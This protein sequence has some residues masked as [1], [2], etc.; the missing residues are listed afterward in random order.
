[1]T[2]T[3][4]H[5]YVWKSATSVEVAATLLENGCHAINCYGINLD[6]NSSMQLANLIV[7]GTQKSKRR[8]REERNRIELYG[9]AL[10]N[11]NIHC[12][13]P[14]LITLKYNS[15]LTYLDLK[16]NRIGDKGAGLIASFM[17]R[18]NSLEEI[19][20]NSNQIGDQGAKSIAKAL[21]HNTALLKIELSRNYIGNK[22][23]KC[24]LSL[25]KTNNTLTG[26][27]LHH[28]HV[29]KEYILE[30]IANLLRQNRKAKA[31]KEEIGIHAFSNAVNGGS[32]APWGRSKLMVIGQGRVGKTATIRSLLGEKFEFTLPSTVGASVTQTHTRINSSCWHKV[33]SHHRK[34]EFTTEM[35]A[36]IAAENLELVK[37]SS[38][39][40]T[41]LWS[42]RQ[43]G[44]S[45]TH[46]SSRGMMSGLQNALYGGSEV[47]VV[48]DNGPCSDFDNNPIRS[49]VF[50]NDHSRK[51]RA[52]SLTL[53]TNQEYELDAFETKTTNLFPNDLPPVMN[54]DEIRSINRSYAKVIESANEHRNDL[55]YTIWDFGG[56]KV[57]YSLHPLF[58]TNYGVYLLVFD[59]RQLIGSWETRRKALKSIKYWL[60][61]KSLYAPGAPIV[62]VGTFKDAIKDR[63]DY[64]ESVNFMLQLI[65][66]HHPQYVK[67]KQD[68][69][70]FF[71][72]ENRTQEGIKLLAQTI[73]NV[74]R[75]QD[76]VKR[77]VSIRWLR[78]LDYILEENAESWTTYSRV[79]FLSKLVGIESSEE[80][81]QMLSFFH[82]L[83][84]LVHFTGTP[85]L[86][87]I[88]ITNPQWL[89]SEICK[90]LRDSKLHRYYMLSL[91]P[92]T[93]S[94][95]VEALFSHGLASRDLLS[96]LW[97]EDKVDFML[98]M[99]RQVL[100]L[101]DWK[102]TGKDTLYLIPSLLGYRETRT[103]IR[104]LLPLEGFR[105]VFDF[106]E[107]FLPIGVFER[108]VCLCVMYSGRNTES[109]QPSL[110]SGVCIISFGYECK[111]HMYERK[112][113]IHFII[114]N[115][116]TP[117]DHLQIILAMM[118]KLK[119]EAVSPPW[120]LE[121]DVNGEF[122]SHEKVK[123]SRLFPWCRSSDSVQ[124]GKHI[125]ELDINSFVN[126]LCIK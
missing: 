27:S 108:L 103:Y 54:E 57:F 66:A 14:I 31:A 25:M 113:K 15:T 73:E 48:S 61:S 47:S 93:L 19:L 110:R 10:G 20:L 38:S 126:R 97:E 32:M 95:D 41:K 82:E 86:N 8:K 112:E 26:L 120:S 50:V 94:S 40:K 39:P 71:P 74:T 65:L 102:F 101:S 77:N 124:P 16:T 63:D 85:E 118:R 98:D 34:A 99:L 18:N 70:V 9:L 60:S 96:K 91:V 13:N 33:N 45:I 6:A 24:F 52:Q 4:F 36:R 119:T 76:F 123:R 1:M 64:L 121:L 28:N 58:L 116:V 44:A 114:T 83:G 81:S 55:K 11:S 105:G 92:Q 49:G 5:E 17:Y 75:Q 84:V 89:V 43:R 90:V 72:V 111:I 69:L 29:Y 67:N 78:C 104:P 87:N 37:K 23:A 107:S 115:S 109:V 51:R 122:I 46:G 3:I 68:E 125:P 53:Y 35:A 22:G 117:L 100:L 62:V 59:I 2:K 7:Q 79:K 56:Q 42:R 30:K 21:R 88:V 80:I 12:F 106:S